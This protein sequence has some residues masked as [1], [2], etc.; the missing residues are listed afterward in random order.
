M[1][2]QDEGERD[3]QRSVACEAFEEPYLEIAVPKMVRKRAGWLS[4]CSS[5]RC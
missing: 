3:M 2:A 5:V 1:S 4:P